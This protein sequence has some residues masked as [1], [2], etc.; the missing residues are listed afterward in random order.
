MFPSFSQICGTPQTAFSSS[1]LYYLSNTYVSIKVI[2]LRLLSPTPLTMSETGDIKV[3]SSGFHFQWIFVKQTFFIGP[4]HAWASWCLLLWPNYAFFVCLHCIPLPYNCLI[5]AT[6][7]HTDLLLW[8]LQDPS[9]IFTGPDVSLDS[10]LLV[11]A[12]ERARQEAKVIFL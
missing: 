4:F 3:S 11:F 8:Q 7:Y 2:Y 5:K 10:H 9:L 1:H 6:H 12:A